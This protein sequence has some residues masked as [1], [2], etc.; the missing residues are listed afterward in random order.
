M[1]KTEESNSSDG[2]EIFWFSIQESKCE[3]VLPVYMAC[4]KQS[5]RD[6]WV[7]LL[8][9]FVS[10]KPSKLSEDSIKEGYVTKQGK[11][12]AAQHL[13]YFVLLQD[14]L[15]YYKSIK[16]KPTGTIFLVGGSIVKKINEEKYVFPV[17]SIGMD[18]LM[19]AMFLQ[20]CWLDCCD[21]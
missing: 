5:E 1:V 21:F 4:Q 15:D 8:Q 13:R 3:G 12:L 11:G 6:A 9:A 19:F 20:G 7:E 17:Q 14:R 18:F 10:S 2:P 16:N